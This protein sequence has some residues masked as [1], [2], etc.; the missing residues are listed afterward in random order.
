MYSQHPYGTQPYKSLFA[1]PNAVLLYLHTLSPGASINQEA[2]T[3]LSL[4]HLGDNLICSNLSTFL[5]QAIL[6]T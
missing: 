5:K 2:E 3:A 6:R 1:K 4:L